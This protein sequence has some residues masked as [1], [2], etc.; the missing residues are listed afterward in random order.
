[1]TTYTTEQLTDILHVSQRT[2]YRYIK[3]G[4]LDAVKIGKQ[5]RV[6]HESLARFL[7][8]GTE[9]NYMQKLRSMSDNKQ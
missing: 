2:L 6:T 8:T 9:E 7:A 3:A 4:Q 1:M 5:F